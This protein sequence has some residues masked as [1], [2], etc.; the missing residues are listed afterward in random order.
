MHLKSDSYFSVIATF[1]EIQDT[2][3]GIHILIRGTLAFIEKKNKQT[4]K[5]PLSQS[6]YCLVVE[7]HITKH[8]C[9]HAAKVTRIYLH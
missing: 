3:S 9:T 2:F 5:K 4:K 6:L 1:K 8:K 7:I